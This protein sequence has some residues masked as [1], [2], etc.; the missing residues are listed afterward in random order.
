MNTQAYTPALG[1]NGLTG[2]YDGLI[3]LLTRERIWRAAV[4]DA[5]APVDGET[6]VDLGAGTGSLGVLIKRQSPAARVVAVDPDRQVRE[7]G[8][9]KARAV[10]VRLEYVTAMGDVEI[11]S[12]P[13]A[14]ADA[15]TCSL[16]LHQCPLDAKRAILANAVRLLKPGGR[17]VLAD[18]GAQPDALMRLGF[19]LVQTLDGFEATEHNRRGVI[20]QLIEAVG[21]VESETVCRVATPTGAITVWRAR[22]AKDL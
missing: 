13:A 12:V 6:I 1:H 16:V 2:L 21:F 9:A 18:Y 11:A 19:L 10:G 22:R 7:I 15:V 14:T 20:P 3:A 17:M 5:L 8:E 4:L